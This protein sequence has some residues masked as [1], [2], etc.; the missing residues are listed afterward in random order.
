MTTG[1]QAR[2][3]KAGH[4][5]VLIL[6]HILGIIN[7]RHWICHAAISNLRYRPYS[8]IRGNIP[9]LPT[10]LTKSSSTRDGISDAIDLEF[11]GFD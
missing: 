9:T 5:L 6:I 11:W 2:A 8:C 7:R 10:Y 4:Y 3:R 1:P